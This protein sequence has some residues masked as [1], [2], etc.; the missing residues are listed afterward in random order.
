MKKQSNP[1]PPD[2]V[3]KPKPPPAPPKLSESTETAGYGRVLLLASYCNEDGCTEDF[4]C[5]DCLQMCNIAIVSKKDMRVLGDFGQ[6]REV[7]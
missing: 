2:G 1:H 4:P 5:A 7:A 6:M 3:E